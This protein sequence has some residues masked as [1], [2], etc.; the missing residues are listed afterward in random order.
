VILSNGDGTASFARCLRLYTGVLK[1]QLLQFGAFQ[2]VDYQKPVRHKLTGMLYVKKSKVLHIR[3]L[4]QI[5]RDCYVQ[6]DPLNDGF[7]HVNDLVE[8]DLYL[9]LTAKEDKVNNTLRCYECD[10]LPTKQYDNEK[11]EAS[12]L[13][14]RDYLQDRSYTEAPHEH[15]MHPFM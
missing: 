8:P 10:C 14:R 5:V 1:G 13:A 11:L 4:N 12:P 3:L 9:R 2:S 7:S 15:S 6:P